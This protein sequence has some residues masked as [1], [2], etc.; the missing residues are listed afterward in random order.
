MPLVDK[1]QNIFT[2][3]NK[4]RT[5]ICF[6]FELQNEKEKKKKKSETYTVCSRPAVTMPSWHIKI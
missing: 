3:N 1:Q 2:L 4:K 6:D 5:P